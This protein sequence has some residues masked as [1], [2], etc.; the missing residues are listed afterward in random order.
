MVFLI[1][2]VACF[3]ASTTRAATP[4][5]PAGYEGYHTYEEMVAEVDRVAAAHPNIVRK[6]SIGRSYEGRELWAV[7]ISDNVLLDEDEPEVVFD[8]LIHAR[9]HITV[10]MTLYTLHLLADNYGRRSRI[11]AL[12][13]TREVFLIF[14]LNP[15]GAEYDISGGRFHHWRKNRQPIPDSEFV[16]VDMNRN[17]AFKWGCCGGSSGNPR[18]STYRGPS[19]WFAPEVVAYRDF[20]RSRE[21]DGVQQ[22]RIAVSWHSY[23]RLVMWAYGYTK[24]NIPS[25]MTRADHRTYV[26]L[27]R[28]AAALNGY[29]AQ[30][31]SDLYISDG[32]ARDW[33]HHALGV[34]HFTF[35][36]GGADFYPSQDR[37]A[38]LTSVNRGAVLYLLEM[39]D[40][41]YRAAG[42]QA[43]HC[44]SLA[45]APVTTEA[46]PYEAPLFLKRPLTD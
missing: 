23:G 16:G 8:S 2:A 29:T 3:G 11:T 38:A 43:T 37:I 6:F 44:G 17:F 32:S 15:D 20:L 14:M 27:G 31:A 46:L 7:K 26:A 39:A 12:V 1:T 9:E 42:L 36:M 41:P 10:E 35:E 4:D 21:V 5:F 18:R 33:S 28:A 24:T 45:T 13:D 22:V 25:T 34:F 40:C 19:A 30:Q